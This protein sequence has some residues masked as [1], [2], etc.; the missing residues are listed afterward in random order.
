[1]DALSL[2]IYEAWN[3]IKTYE[4]VLGGGYG[5]NLHTGRLT[6]DGL[7]DHLPPFEVQRDT[8]K[9]MCHLKNKDV[10]VK[11]KAEDSKIVNF[12]CKAED[13]KHANVYFDGE[14]GKINGG[15]SPAN[16]ALYS[17]KI[18]K[19]LYQNWYNLPVLTKNNKPMILNMLIHANMD[20]AY[21]DGEKMV[22]GDGVELFYP[23]ISLTVGAHEISHGFTQQHSNLQ[24]FGQAG[25]LNEAFSDM[26]AQAA[27]YFVYKKNNWRI[28][29]EIIKR[30][31]A[32]GCLDE[33][34]C[35]LR[36]MDHP[37]KDG[38]SIENR[39]D[40]YDGLDVHFSSGLFNKLFYLLANSTN[41][42]TKKAFDVM[43][44]ANMDYWTATSSFQE[45]ACGVL[46]ATWYYK[47]NV[48]SARDAIKKVGL[49]PERCE[50]V[51]K[52]YG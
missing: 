25:G 1:M 34:D 32:L 38:H 37:V 29:A 39:K 43:V 15:Y 46:S 27:Q 23:L 11:N 50:T 49:N 51:M 33:R 47:Y 4:N 24:Y 5:G 2:E 48:N 45:A 17:G 42:D 41:W 8:L 19:A 52:N 35:A 12:T 3:D 20:N 9:Q 36:Y 40:Y 22:F 10:V 13:T 14:L 44:K 30:P 16:D 7:S 18:V 26:A 6:Y 31:S 28:G 21:W